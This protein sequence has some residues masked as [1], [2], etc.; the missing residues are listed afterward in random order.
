MGS[1]I[2]EPLRL[3]LLAFAGAV[4]AQRPAD[5]VLGGYM[6]RWRLGQYGDAPNAYLHRFRGD[7]DDRA[8][9]DHPY[10]NV[11]VV[12][13]GGYDEHVHVEQLT[14]GPD[15]KYLTFCRRVHPGQVVERKASHFHRLTLVGGVEAISLFIPGP[16]TRRW[17][18]LD[19]AQGWVD[20]E[21]YG[22][23]NP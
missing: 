3:S 5:F 17:G 20:W 2:P 10:D 23:A 15:G 14:V 4:M 16:R 21:A 12:L 19:P 7:D 6:E 1:M 13:S 11:S 22:R 8:L 9:H 18:F